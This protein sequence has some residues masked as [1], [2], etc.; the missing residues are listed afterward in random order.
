MNYPTFVF[1]IVFCVSQACNII[2]NTPK[3]TKGQKQKNPDPKC[4]KQHLFHMLQAGSWPTLGLSLRKLFRQLSGNTYWSV[5]NHPLPSSPSPSSAYLTLYTVAVF[6]GDLWVDRQLRC[7]KAWDFYSEKQWCSL[8][9]HFPSLLAA[10]MFLL[11]DLPQLLFPPRWCAALQ[12]R[13]GGAWSRS[14]AK[15]RGS[16]QEVLTACLS[17]QSTVLRWWPPQQHLGLT[18]FCYSFST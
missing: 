4:P 7:F 8:L 11:W 6:P 16:P 5:G 9:R 14:S 3:I 12:R 15:S 18:G 1:L 17:A 10:V 2:W 13:A